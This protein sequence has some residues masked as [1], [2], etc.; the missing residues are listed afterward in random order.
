MTPEE[1]ARQH[2]DQQL[3]QAD[4]IVT[5]IGLINPVGNDFFFSGKGW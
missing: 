4:C 1:L 3:M 2:I 5:D